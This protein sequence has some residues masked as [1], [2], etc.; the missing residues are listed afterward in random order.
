MADD[1][2]YELHQILENA[3]F[4][5]LDDR[6]FLRIT[7][8]DATRWLNGMVTNSIQSLAPGEGN[9]NFLLNAQGRIQGDGTIYRDG[10]EFLLETSTSQVESI[11]QHLDRF[12]IMDDVEL[13]PAYTEKQGLLLIGAKAPAILAASELPALDPLHLSHAKSLLLLAPA[14]GSIPRYEL[15]DDPASI[16]LLRENLSNA[17]AVEVSSASLEQLRLIEATPLF[18]QDIRD[19][20]L[21]Q[22]TAQAHALHFN[23]GCYLGQEIVERIRSRGQV[24]RTFT[25][26]RLIGDLPTLPAPIEANGK[27]VGELTSAALVPLPEGPTLLA[28][29]Y[30]R[31]EALDTHQP[32]TYAGGTAIPRSPGTS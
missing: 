3:A 30:I 11:Q 32:L 8:P 14:A 26:F 18:S 12:I 23:K 1:T 5:P 7:G 28:L 13:S 6:A 15:W 31:R 29:G 4:A 20:D 27:P 10:D 9:Y 2:Q 25:A 22:E 21:P 16:A 17:G 19:R 24:H